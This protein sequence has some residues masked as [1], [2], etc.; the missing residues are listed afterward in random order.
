MRRTKTNFLTPLKWVWRKQTLIGLSIFALLFAICLGLSGIPEGASQ[1]EIATAQ[2]AS[3]VSEILKNPVNAPFKIITF[4]V[5]KYSPTVRLVR[6]VSFLFY[7]LA[8]IALF[9]AL[10]HW[11]TLQAS[12]ITTAA[13]ATNSVV[14]ATGRLGTPLIAFMGFF[15]FSS[16]ILWQLHSKSNKLVPALV[17]MAAAL[18]LYTPGVVWFMGIL[19]IFYFNRIKI[20]YL[21]VRK[22]AVIIGAFLAVLLISPLIMS[23]VRDSSYLKEWLLIPDRFSL[24]NILTSLVNVPAGFIYKMPEYPLINISQLPVFDLS[25]GILFLIGLNAYRKKVKLDRTRLMFVSVIFGFFAGAMGQVIPAIIFLLPFAYSIIAAGIEF[26]LDEW[27]SIFPR[28]P[29]ARSFGLILVTLAGIFSI[30]YQT[31]RFFVVWPQT[32]ETRAEYRQS[33]IINN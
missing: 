10:R 12:A 6:F 9:Y 28:N 33:R 2:S 19:G 27:Y 11:H 30:Y 18:F 15:V 14:L 3:S 20:P 29:I 1:Q 5:T 31:S 26:L 16:L 4:A 23:F 17:L 7:A 24:S 22:S 21:N 32:P 8:C 13:F 25:S